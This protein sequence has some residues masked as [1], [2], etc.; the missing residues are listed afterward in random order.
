MYHAF[1]F[2]Y[3]VYQTM[4]TRGPAAITVLDILLMFVMGV[5]PP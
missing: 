2:H 5:P 1:L 4:Y 3:I